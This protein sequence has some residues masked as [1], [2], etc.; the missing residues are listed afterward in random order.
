MKVRF[1]ADADL[2]NRIVRGIKRRGPEVDFRTAHAAGLSKLSDTEV[3]K[4]AAES[5]RVLVTSRQTNHAKSFLGVHQRSNHSRC[6]H[7]WKGSLNT[8]RRRR[9]LA[10]LG[11]QRS[12]GVAQPIG[13][14]STL[15]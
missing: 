11:C 1:Q 10:D 7:H 5:G 13:M 14:D 2:D 6:L 9:D 4:V 8:H 15:S 3:L 12:G